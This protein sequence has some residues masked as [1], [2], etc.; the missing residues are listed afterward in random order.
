MK[1]HGSHP[2]AVTLLGILLGAVLG[3][4]LPLPGAAQAKTASAAE[5]A[6]VGAAAASAGQTVL[7]A[8]LQ[9]TAAEGVPGV[10]VSVWQGEIDF[11]QLRASGI[12]VVY[13]RAAEGDT[14][15]AAFA[16]NAEAAAAAGLK[17]GCYCY[18]TARTVQQAAAQAE[19]FWAMIADRPMQC[20]PA[21]D[22]E[23]FGNLPRAEINAVAKAFLQRLEELC[24]EAPLLYTDEYR[25]RTLWS[26]ELADWPLWV[27]DYA[28]RDSGDLPADLG[29]WKS[30]AGFQYADSGRIDGISTRVDCDVFYP[31]AFL[32]S[33]TE[34]GRAPAA[35]VYTVRR[36]D[37]LWAI[38]HRFGCSVQALA[39]CNHLRDPNL[40]FPGQV[41]RLPAC[42]RTG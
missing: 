3:L 38:A 24:G 41:L 10:D 42:A 33:K 31:S 28:A 27:A 35:A 40:I 39:A 21:M 32:G 20:R 19:A 1:K 6:A 29:P 2:A 22:F 30:C 13:I 4:L 18:V 12:Q 15:D 8:A 5:T 9:Q 11:E 16:Q 37:T 7:Q 23:S 36:G 14:E 17:T 25:A 26:A 34:E